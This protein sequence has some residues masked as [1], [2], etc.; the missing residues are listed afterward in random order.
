MTLARGA[1]QLVVLWE[2]GEGGKKG[3]GREGGREGGREEGSLTRKRSTRSSRPC[4]HPD[5]RRKRTL[6]S[7]PAFRVVREGGRDGGRD[8]GGSEWDVGWEMQ[9][10]DVEEACWGTKMVCVS[11]GKYS[12]LNSPLK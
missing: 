5:L 3:L 12:P 10:E 9:D 6:E 4:T 7:S 11:G 8:E 1:K 2:G